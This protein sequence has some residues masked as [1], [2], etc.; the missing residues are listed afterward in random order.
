[1]AR[2]VADARL[3]LFGIRHHG[4]G[5]ARALVQ[6]LDALQPDAML[7]EGP[8]DANAVLQLAQQPAMKPPV[9][10]LIYDPTTPQRCAFYPF[11]QFSPEWQAL[12]YALK[13]AIPVELMD[14]P[15]A[16]RLA[17]NKAAAERAIDLPND[18]AS[19]EEDATVEETTDDPLRIRRD[20]LLWLA[21]AAGYD[22]S[23][24]WWEAMVEERQDAQGVFEAILDAM[25]ALREAYDQQPCDCPAE[26][27]HE[28]QREA[29][30]R[31][32]I[33]AT[34]KQGYQRVA[35]ICGAWHTPAL[36]TM[37]TIKQDNATLKGLAKIKTLATWVPWTHGRLARQSGYGAG[38]ES[39]GW[40]HYLWQHT[41]RHP[42]DSGL[43]NGWL[44]R[45]AQRLRAEGLDISPAH[46]IEAVRLAE[47]LAA[48]RDRPQPGL[49]EMDDSIESVLLGGD[50]AVM[51][52]IHQQ[53]IIGQTL[54]KVPEECPT[55]PLQQDLIRQ[56][57][58]LRLKVTADFKYLNLDLRRA[59]DLKRSQLFHRLRLLEIPWGNP[60]VAQQKNRGTFRESWRLQWQPEF[61]IQLIEASI[62]GNTVERAAS[63]RV[64]EC[65]EQSDQLAELAE[66]IDHALLAN[67]PDAVQRA[68]EQLNQRA[69]LSSDIAH[70]LDTLPSLISIVRYG[71]VRNS[72]AETMVHL[73][74]HMI[75]RICIGLLSACHSLDDQAAG[76]MLHSIQSAHSAITLLDRADHQQPWH[77][78]LHRLADSDSLHGLIRGRSCRLLLDGG[79]LDS[80]V[81]ARRFGV[82]LSPAVEPSQAAAW[83]E[84]FLS[85]SGILLIHD[86]QLWAILDDWVSQLSHPHFLETLPLLRRTF[87]KFS[88]P[89]RR[90]M[91]E[92]I[93]Q[94]DRPPGHSPDA[95]EQ[96]LNTERARQVLPILSELLAGC[97]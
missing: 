41:A 50:P 49:A 84:G 33:R 10:L 90:T 81:S 37:P 52:L 31:K 7:I 39:P 16:H 53:L 66:L 20:P 86:E 23:E 25:S 29:Y 19:D 38:I 6:A 44:C 70:Q 56:Q 40:Y 11:A 93:L 30:M 12:H 82:A 3:H 65:S 62:C 76:A 87:A 34:L 48:L 51:A 14:L 75:S 80:E 24:R 94:T 55:V 63:S 1:M 92:R 61:A 36:A 57:K 72:D 79:Y 68:I 58:S 21:Q 95:A 73:V 15:Q 64:I 85:D 74:D 83:I 18:Q 8:P 78:A 42:Y 17:E 2:P 91:G 60:I 69:S 71:S 22:D 5:S 26:Q 28:Q 46:V 54:G 9:A 4:P 89:E 45:V 67:L 13:H 96:P 27:R 47:T 35:V 77:H 97:Q 32:T 88:Q 59:L 43:A